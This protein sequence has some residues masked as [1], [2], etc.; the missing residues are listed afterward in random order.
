MDIKLTNTGDIDFTGGDIQYANGLQA[1]IADIV[2]QGKGES[3]RNVTTGVNASNY[4][5]DN[6]NGDFL[7][8]IRIELEKEGIKVDAIN[9]KTIQAHYDDNTKY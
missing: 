5:L 8:K 6:S 2:I 3:K 7:R 9:I 4:L 1:H